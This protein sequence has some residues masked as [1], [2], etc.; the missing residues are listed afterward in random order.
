MT[1]AYLAGLVAA[2]TDATL[3]TMDEA[4]ATADPGLVTLVPRAVRGD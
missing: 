4:L 1:D 2:R 3:A